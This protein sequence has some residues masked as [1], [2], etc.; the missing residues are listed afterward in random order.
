MINRR[1]GAFI[2][3][4]RREQDLTQEQFAEKLG[5][6][7]RSVSRW[8]N[9]STLPDF[10]LMESICQITGVTLPELLSGR[11][12]DPSDKGKNHALSIL[13]LWDREKLAK[14]KT[15]NTWFALGLITLL[16]AV[17]CGGILSRPQLW[18]LASLGVFFHGLGFYH[19]NRDTGLTDSQKAILASSGDP[20]AMNQPEELLTFARKNQNVAAAQYK[21]AF[22]VI[23]ENL[24]EHERASFAMIANE[25]CIGSAPGIW[26]CGIAVTQDRVFLCGETIAGRFMTRTVMDVCEKRDIRSVRYTDRSILLRT[27]QSELT[28]RGKDLGPLGEA[29]QNAVL[30]RS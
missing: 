3:T 26:H 13:A 8:E 22:R 24:A 29:F 19:N 7:N 30:P 5:V 9:G 2:S 27:T 12:E 1:I 6:S 16:A 23:C 4:L 25:Y 10:S 18:V 14:N 15:L 28:I 20:V 17:L 21:T 11:R